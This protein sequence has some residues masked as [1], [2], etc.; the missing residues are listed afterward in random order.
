MVESGPRNDRQKYPH[1]MY[2]GRQARGYEVHSGSA[3][4]ADRCVQ[5]AVQGYRPTTESVDQ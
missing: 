1:I 5:S 3:G 4:N 2:E